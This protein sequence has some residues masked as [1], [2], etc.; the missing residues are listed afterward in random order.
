MT[1]ADWGFLPIAM[2]FF[3]AAAAGKQLARIS[4]RFY[5]AIGMWHLPEIAIEWGFRFAGVLGGVMALTGFL[6][7][8]SR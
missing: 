3:L 1:M 2:L 8:L 7:A 5:E 4:V 6:A